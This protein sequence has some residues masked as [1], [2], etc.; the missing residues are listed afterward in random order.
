MLVD[1][2]PDATDSADLRLDGAVA[3]TC[4]SGEVHARVPEN[5]GHVEVGRLGAVAQFKDFGV[6][7]SHALQY[8]QDCSVRQGMNAQSQTR[9]RVLSALMADEAE[10]ARQFMRRA[11]EVTGLS[12]YAL[13]RKAGISPTTIT[14][15]LND[16][17]F[18]FVP[19]AATLAKIGD[20]AAL[21]PPQ[22][23][24]PS[25]TVEAVNRKIPLIGEVRAGAW[26]EVPDEPVVEDE[27]PVFL[28]DYQRASLFALRVAGRSMDQVYADGCVVIAAPPV[29][30]GLQ[31]GDIVV[32]RRHRNGLSETTLKEMVREADGSYSLYPR[33][34]DT[35]LKPLP[36]TRDRDCDDGPEIIG[37]VVY[38]IAPTRRG[39]GPLVILDD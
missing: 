17:T 4:P 18:K 24:E 38:S 21:T 34:S 32:V 33:S 36:L 3:P 39:R 13:A 22:L 16:P 27:I 9:R 31:V 15:P 5:G 7:S 12:P 25:P 29:E 1:R 30:I 20:A 23:S 28:P 6:S 37:V 2:L 11:L 10:Q 14:R 19:K 35:S 26:S 8:V